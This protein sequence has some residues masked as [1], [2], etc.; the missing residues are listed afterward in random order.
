MVKPQFEVG[1]Q[2]LGPRGVVHDPRLRAEAV[3]AVAAAAAGLGWHTADVCRSPLPG[4]S[5]N[6]EF[7][8]WLRRA[9]A[10]A[11]DADRITAAVTEAP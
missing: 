7:F 10:P 3:C 11:L 2:R 4:P 8:L 5:G 6:V 9:A 1:K